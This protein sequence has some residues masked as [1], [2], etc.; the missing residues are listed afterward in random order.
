MQG[1]KSA[2]PTKAHAA[3]RGTSS[4]NY[5]PG[6]NSPLR[7][8]AR[9]RGL[10]L[11]GEKDEGFLL[12]IYP[13]RYGHGRLKAHRGLP[14]WSSGYDSTLPMQGAR[15]QSLAGE[16]PTCHVARPKKEKRKKKKARRDDFCNNFLKFLRKRSDSRMVQMAFICST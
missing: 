3:G 2:L 16:D 11:E 8:Q 1:P 4:E 12:F 10:D 9:A 15:V 14:W 6:K 5:Q 13:L 7:S